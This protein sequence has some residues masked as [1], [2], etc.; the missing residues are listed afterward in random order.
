MTVVRGIDIAVGEGRYVWDFGVFE[1]ARCFTAGGSLSV[2]LVGGQVE[3][4]KE[5]QIRADDCDA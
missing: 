3:G 1:G 5:D 2:L 4:D